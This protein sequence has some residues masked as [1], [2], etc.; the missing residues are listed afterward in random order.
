MMN[1]QNANRTQ[2][3]RLLCVAVLSLG[4]LPAFSARVAAQQDGSGPRA[5]QR[6]T[7]GETRRE[8]RR[9]AE[10]APEPGSVTRQKEENR[11]RWEETQRTIAI[12]QAQMALKNAELQMLDAEFQLLQLGV[13]LEGEARRPASEL[14]RRDRA[15]E[16]ERGDPQEEREPENRESAQKTVKEPRNIVIQK[17]LQD[18]TIPARDDDVSLGELV[19]SVRRVSRTADLPDGIPIYFDPPSLLNAGATME[20][21][22]KPNNDGL[23]LAQ[24]LTQVLKPIGLS[25]QVEGGLMKIVE[26]RE[27]EARTNPEPRPNVDPKTESQAGEAADPRN[28]SNESS[29]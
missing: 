1:A 3:G 22:V 12:L 2:F 27:E 8:S 23:N 20:S 28:P 15:R 18:L 13:S 25:Y 26:R 7:R 16:E 17:T 4:A 21:K 19:K 10:R 11:R 9:Q 29:R 5:T 14:P 6:R 24:Y